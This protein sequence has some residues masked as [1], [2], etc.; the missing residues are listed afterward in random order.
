MGRGYDAQRSGAIAFREVD[1]VSR[2]ESERLYNE[3]AVQSR[4]QELLRDLGLDREDAKSLTA[5]EE[6]GMAHVPVRHLGN[7]TGAGSG[8]PTVRTP[9]QESEHPRRSSARRIRAGPQCAHWHPL[10]YVNYP[11]AQSRL[12]ALLAATEKWRLQQPPG[13]GSYGSE[14]GIVQS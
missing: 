10:A 12:T 8:G 11:V 7:E 5:G 3:H 13:C 9:R 4:V 2:C 14:C 1:A 6:E